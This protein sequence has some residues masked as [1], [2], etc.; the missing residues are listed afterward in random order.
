[1]SVSV[2]HSAVSIQLFLEKTGFDSAK[3]VEDAD[4]WRRLTAESL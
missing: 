2:Q 1:M 3:V 4:S